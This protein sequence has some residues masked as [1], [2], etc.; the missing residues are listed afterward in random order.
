MCEMGARIP[1]STPALG[2]FPLHI[3]A[4]FEPPVLY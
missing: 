1:L 3:L 4:G 2:A